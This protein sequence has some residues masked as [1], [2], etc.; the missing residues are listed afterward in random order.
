MTMKYASILNGKTVFGDLSGPYRMNERLGK[1]Q[2]VRGSKL[3]ASVQE[4]IQ[5]NPA[6][7]SGVDKIN[8]AGFI[9]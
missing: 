7:V 6:L 9:L 4:W 3:G 2:W 1:K 5:I 8:L